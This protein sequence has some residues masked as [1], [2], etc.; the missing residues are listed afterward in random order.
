VAGHVEG[1]WFLDNSIADQQSE[2]ALYNILSV[3]ALDGDSLPFLDDISIH[4]GGISGNP[5]SVHSALVSTFFTDARGRSSRGRMYLGTIPLAGLTIDGARWDTSTVHNMETAWAGFR[6]DMASHD[7]SLCV[8]SRKL[9]T[10]RVVGD[11][12]VNSYLG[13]QRRRSEREERP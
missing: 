5:A 6:T 12:R 10:L 4:T 2:A 8:L 11:I 7:L 1:A 13:A 9:E 3:T